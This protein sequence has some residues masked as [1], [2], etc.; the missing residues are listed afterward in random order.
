VKKEIFEKKGYLSVSD[1]MEEI[2]KY[3]EG[4]KAVQELI[5]KP[6][7]IINPAMANR[8]STGGALS[9]TSIWNHI[10]KFLPDEVYYLL[11]ER[12]NKIKK[13]N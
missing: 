13:R 1:S 3:P 2:I 12:L 10:N 8:M 6:L 7:E 9:F 5:A 4:F 11:N